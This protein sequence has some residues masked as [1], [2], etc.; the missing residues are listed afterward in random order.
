MPPRKRA[1]KPPKIGVAISTHNRRDLLDESLEKWLEVLPTGA[2]LVVVDDASDVPVPDR[3]G[4]TV[5]RNPNRLGVA[6]T[7]NRG[8]EALMA[9]G[10]D[11]LFLADD[12]VYPVHPLWWKPYVESPEPHLH[13]GWEHRRATPA[14][15]TGWPPRIDGADNV[16]DSYTFPRG[17]LLY[18]TREVV[19]VVGGMNP[20]HGVF[21]GE[22][23]EWSTRIHAAGFGTWPYVDVKDSR[24]IWWARDREVGNTVGSSFE[25]A[26]RRV[27]HAANGRRWDEKFTGWPFMP[28]GGTG[29]QD[30]SLGVDLTGSA[31]AVSA[32]RYD[33][34]LDHAIGMRPHGVCL[35]FGTGSGH[36]TRR[37]AKH[38]FVYTFDWFKGL[39]GKWRDGFEAGMFAG[40]VFEGVNTHV[41]EGRVEDT[42]PLFDLD[43][44]GPVGLVCFDLDLYSSTKAVLDGLGDRWTQVFQPGTYVYFDEWHGYPGADGEHE[45]KAFRQFAE[46]HPELSW[47]VVGRGPEQW[48]IRITGNGENQ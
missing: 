21:S 19:D 12:D 13:Y 14:D 48:L 31:H 24:A 20:A 1:P 43:Q 27:M 3:A 2:A 37:I 47:V 28:Y 6:M 25:L 29:Q 5:I 45:Q 7:K 15:K 17:V 18:V 33:H 35:E 32:D 22:H 42:V 26:D 30:W 11:H 34:V 4:V 9:A 8:I 39:P 16:H 38:Q 41:V 40:P 44:A 23:V 46:Q 10:V 36:S